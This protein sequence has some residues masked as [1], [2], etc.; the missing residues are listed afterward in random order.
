MIAQNSTTSAEIDMK[1]SRES[2]NN[3]VLSLLLFENMEREREVFAR[4]RLS[5]L[6][7]LSSIFRLAN[8]LESFHWE[9]MIE[10]QYLAILAS[11]PSHVAGLGLLLPKVRRASF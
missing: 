3:A 2:R 6:K 4:G 9:F 7:F 8:L 11:K 1:N 10:I 5:A